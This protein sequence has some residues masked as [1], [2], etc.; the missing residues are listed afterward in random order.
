MRSTNPVLTR[1][2][3]QQGYR[4]FQPAPGVPYPYQD[5]ATEPVARMRVE[6]VINKT[7]YMLL[8]VL[9]AA[10]ATWVLLPWN[11]SYPIAVA[12]SLIGFV[13]VMVV[14]MR[15]TLPIGGAL[16][17][18]AVEGVFVGAWSKILELSFPGIV[19]QAVVATVIACF[20][21]LGA[22]RYGV[23]L[24]GKLGRLVI[25]AVV[26][27]AILMLVNLVFSLAGISLGLAQVGGGASLLSMGI[28]ALG[29][30]LAMAC[31]LMDLDAV[32]Q[33]I[34]MGAAEPESW[35]HALGLTVTLVWLYTQLL[36]VLSY[37]RN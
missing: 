12:S 29:V 17:Y 33:N 37:F 21:T 18:A 25:T 10:G 2:Q 19:M 34:R 35:R 22:Y 27:Y 8:V 3:T 15:R 26:A 31:L 30:V 9:A 4:Q 11:L 23:R 16:L 6:D 32:E 20:V 7:V 1:P 13:T 24:R 5:Y 36:R 28:G 14:S